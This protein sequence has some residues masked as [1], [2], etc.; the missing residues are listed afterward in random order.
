M[1]AKEIQK[2]LSNAQESKR[3]ADSVEDYF[4][5][6]IKINFIQNVLKSTKI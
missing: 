2:E 5:F 4:S 3:N 6:E 1:T